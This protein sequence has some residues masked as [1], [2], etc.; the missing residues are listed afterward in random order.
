VSLALASTA[1]AQQPL[2]APATAVPAAAQQ[3]VA[4][5]LA[6]TPML[7]RSTFVTVDTAVLVAIPNSGALPL[8]TL[9]AE[10][11]EH[12]RTLAVQRVSWTLGYR[13]ITGDVVGTDDQFH[14]VVADDGTTSG[15][16][17]DGQRSFVVARAG[18][19][20]VHVVQQFE[21]ALTP[22]QLRCGCDH[23]HA[24]V[25]PIVPE[26][27][28]SL[29]PPARGAVPARAA[30][31]RPL[32][33]RRGCLHQQRLERSGRRSGG[34]RAERDVLRAGFHPRHA[35]VHGRARAHGLLLGPCHR[36]G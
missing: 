5:E 22:A 6:A 14:L 33:R 18:A 29:A 23:T 2:F 32:L 4:N 13:V 26:A 24:V 31:R 12:S 10:L 30:E 35:D 34:L 9:T 3:W 25:S 17:H 19:S 21:Q 36:G 27:A 20:T 8:A 1:L 28:A 16:F 7:T 15:V 11:F